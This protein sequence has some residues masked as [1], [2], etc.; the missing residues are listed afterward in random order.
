[1]DKRPVRVQR[2]RHVTP[3]AVFVCEG[4]GVEVFLVGVGGSDDAIP[5]HRLCGLCVWC[6]TFVNNDQVMETRRACEP[7][8]WVSERELRGIVR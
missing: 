6:C 2:T 1:M 3:A 4:C 8:G 7:G 5:A